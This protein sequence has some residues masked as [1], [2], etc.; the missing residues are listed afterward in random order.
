MLKWFSELFPPCPV[1]FDIGSRYDSLFSSFKGEVHYFEP[2][3]A[4]LEKLK[5]VCHNGKSFFNNFGLSSKEEKLLY[6]PKYQ[7]FYDRKLN[8]TVADDEVEEGQYFLLREARNYIN[9]NNIKEIDFVKIDTEGFEYEVLKGFGDYLNNVKIVQ[10][11]YGGTYKDK[12]IKMIDVINLLK[13]YGF[14]S[15]FYLHNLQL[16]TDFSDHYMYC[17][18]LAVRTK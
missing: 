2:V 7:S 9:E 16:I 4:F 8:I 11:E 1:I 14:N 18:I 13:T 5:T 6:Y 17:N 3:P 15:F 10:F 12:G